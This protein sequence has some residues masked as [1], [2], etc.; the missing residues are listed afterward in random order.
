VRTLAGTFVRS[1]TA[2]IIVFVVEASLV[3]LAAAAMSPT[4]YF[5]AVQIIGTLLAFVLNKYWAFGAATTGRGVF[6][7]MKSMA[8]FFG[9]FVLNIALPCAAMSRLAP[10]AAFAASQIVVG[11]AWTFPLNRWWVFTDV[12]TRTSTRGF[13]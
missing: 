13:A 1:V 11:V 2:S 6:E 5:A 3:A 8:V 10:V 4:F 7:G 12:S 9:S